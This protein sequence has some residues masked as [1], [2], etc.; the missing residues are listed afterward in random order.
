MT[1]YRQRDLA[2]LAG[3]SNL[4]VRSPLERLLT[5]VEQNTPLKVNFEDVSG[6]T[7]DIPELRL[8]PHFWMHTCAFCV[9][10]QSRA[11]GSADC[12]K[13]KLAANRL[14]FGR[15]GVFSGQCHLGLTDI[16]KPLVVG[17]RALGV[18]YLGS[19]VLIGTE[20]LGRR[21]IIRYC[22]RRRFSPDALL[23]QFDAIPRVTAEELARYEAQ[24]NLICELARYILKASEEPLEQFRAETGRSLVDERRR[25]PLVQQA[26]RMVGQ[27][28]SEPLEVRDLA[29]RLRCHPDYLSRAFRL[30][31]GFTIRDYIARVR[32]DHARQLMANPL[33]TLSEVA[34]ACGFAD[35]S[36]FSRA[37]KHYFGLRPSLYD[38][39]SDDL[40]ISFA[41]ILDRIPNP[42]DD[43][44]KK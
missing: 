44:R 15:G 25:L 6:I 2:S 39:A 8:S 28:F 41:E 1:S 7:L 17:G 27:L 12:V 37:F 9:L 23:E 24:A 14:A 13:N 11:I 36:H 16:V 20:E 30:E 5:M 43:L 32:I 42:A 26:M 35:H 31:T 29:T 19:V 18:F 33:H 21:R 3:A 4:S 40:A 22:R 38:S 34:S 10:A